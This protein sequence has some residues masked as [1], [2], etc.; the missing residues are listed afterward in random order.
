MIKLKYS[1]K[2][3][4]KNSILNHKILKKYYINTFPNSKYSLDLIIEDILF[5]L[6]SGVSWRDSR[7]AVNWQSL[8]WHFQRFVKFNIFKS[9][10]HQLRNLYSKRNSIELQII[11][12]TFVMNKFGK[13]KIARN[14]FFKNKNCNKVSIIS[15]SS[16]IP[17]S[18][19][20]NT[21]NVHDLSFV[22]KH[23]SDLFVLTKKIKSI[24]LLA[25]K[26]Y[27]SNKV[28][29]S[30]K[31]RKYILMYPNKVNMIEQNNI[32]SKLYKKR[33]NVEHTFQKLKLFKRIQLRYDSN[34][35]SYFSFI[36]MACSF[37]I[38]RKLQ[39]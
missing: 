6:K 18:V 13:N 33:I 1:F 34:V 19:L 20:I 11:D 12:S 30:I 16:G 23:V 39:K 17:L 25:D 37:L 36:F 9:I 4:I 28:K 38:F 32:D 15:D 2:E 10:F 14:K 24:T 35:S 7:S 31:L 3:T 22:E 26:G 8:F 21:G 27:V 29:N 5:V